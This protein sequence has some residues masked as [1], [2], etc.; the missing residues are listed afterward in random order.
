[1]IVERGW[2]GIASRT[3]CREAVYHNTGLLGLPGPSRRRR[4][5]S[6]ADLSSQKRQ[7]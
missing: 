4:L 2:G 7:R 3:Q 6:V 1:M 5:R